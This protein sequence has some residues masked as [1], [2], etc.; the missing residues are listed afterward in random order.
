M[1]DELTDKLEQTFARLRG[2][3][4]LTEADIKEGLREVRRVLLERLGEQRLKDLYAHVVNSPQR[5]QISTNTL[6]GTGPGNPRTTQGRGDQI[7]VC[8]DH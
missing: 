3:G 8:L 4:T 5:A 2:K 6:R 7:Q 1:F